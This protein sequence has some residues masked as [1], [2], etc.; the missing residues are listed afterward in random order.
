MLTTFLIAATSPSTTA[1]VLAPAPY[2]KELAI[3]FGFFI[4]STLVYVSGFFVFGLIRNLRMQ[5]F[6]VFFGPAIVR[7]RLAQVLFRLNVIPFGGYMKFR[8][9][10]PDPDANLDFDPGAL[11]GRGARGL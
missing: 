1:P 5:E 9:H 7:V 4:L 10:W 11:D 2:W 8:G 6:G 3:A